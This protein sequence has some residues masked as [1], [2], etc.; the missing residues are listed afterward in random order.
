MPVVARPIVP[1]QLQA[2]AVGGKQL[3]AAEL[4]EL[5]AARRAFKK[6]R[7]AIVVSSFNAWTIAIFGG[8]TL[9]C[10]F[11]SVT[12]IVGGLLLSGVALIEFRGRSGVRRLDSS[13]A[14]K[15]AFNQLVLGVFLVGYA[16]WSLHAA[17]SA[18]SPVLPG[19]SDP[20]LVDLLGPTDGL[21]R[22]INEL[23]Y[24]GVI[25]IGIGVQGMAALFYFRCERSIRTYLRDTPDWIVRLQAAGF[26][27]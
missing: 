4:L 11:P 24:G 18:P 23:V 20:Q 15:L 19:I 2:D 10:G 27:I 12:G 8:L 22:Q 25:A 21:V 16:L 3:S 5:A 13:A 6:I 1:P 17:G 7:R 9:I 26:R 14:R